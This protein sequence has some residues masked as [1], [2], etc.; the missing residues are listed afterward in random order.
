MGEAKEIWKER[1]GL[2]MPYQVN[3]ALMKATGN[4]HAKFMHCLPAYHDTETTIGKQI[5][6]TYGISNGLEV[7]N[8]VFESEVNLAFEQAEN[9]LQHHQGDTR[10][11]PGRLTSCVLSLHWV[12]MHF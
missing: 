4:P 7:T 9:R 5:S 10:R 11:N 12:G 2:L 6:E 1:I 3:E 8:D